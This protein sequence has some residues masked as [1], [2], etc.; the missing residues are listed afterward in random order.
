MKINKKILII[1][2]MVL[3][4]IFGLV[5][6]NQWKHHGYEISALFDFNRAELKI[7][8]PYNTGGACHP[9]VV[10]FKDGF[11]GYKYWMAYTPYPK[12]KSRY[13]NPCILV[14]NDLSNWKVPTGL[15]EACLDDLSNNTDEK[16]YNS[17]THLLYNP[18]TKELECW[19]RFVN[20]KEIVIY[21]RRA[22][23]GNNW[24]KKEVVM[25]FANRFREDALSPAIIYENGKYKIWYV[26]KNKIWYMETTDLKNYSKPKVC[27]VPINS[28]L[29]PWHLDVEKTSNGY[30]M[31]YVA[32]PKKAKNH[33]HMK[34]Y[35]SM[36]KDNVKWSESKVILTERKYKS[37]DNGGIY[38]SCLLFID[39]KYH[40]IYTGWSKNENVGLGYVSGEDLASLK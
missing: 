40:I 14:S 2:I 1:T 9:K 30:E 39:G 16:V 27:Q 20:D 35:H 37:W 4:I 25:R 19:W 8:T 7:D 33:F 17:D 3:T 32:Y 15:N 26:F 38:R 11:N 5:I 13:E 22:V 24:T 10:Y 31:I 21:R 34:L 6:K 18:D 12:H 36:S 23:D 28:Q 29:N